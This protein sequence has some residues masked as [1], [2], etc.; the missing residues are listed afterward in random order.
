MKRPV[1]F[2]YYI[3]PLLQYHLYL[4]SC[5][6]GCLRVFQ[7]EIYFRTTMP[8]QVTKACDRDQFL[9]SDSDNPLNRDIKLVKIELC[10]T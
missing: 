4:I 6:V 10:S 5:R 2:L 3:K 8:Q 9:T 7:R 1:I